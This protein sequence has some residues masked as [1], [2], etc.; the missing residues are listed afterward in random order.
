MAQ[1]IDDFHNVHEKVFAIKEPGQYIECIFWRAKAI[2]EIPKPKI[3]EAPS[4][5][6]D[7]SAA[8][9]G[10]RYA[11]FRDLG[12]MVE[13]PIYRGDSLGAGNIISAPAII[14]EP[15]MTVVVFPG[16]KVRV[17]KFGSYLFEID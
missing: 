1:L 8:L 5:D 17:T 2:G 16:S 9:K 3:K 4:G 10:N 14:E 12:G 11:Y 13:T 7:V 15:T 6:E